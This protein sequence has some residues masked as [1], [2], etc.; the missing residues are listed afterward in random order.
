[1]DTSSPSTPS[2]FLSAR[3]AFLEDGEYRG[4][5]TGRPTASVSSGRRS[6]HHSRVPARNVL[7]SSQRTVGRAG[8]TDTLDSSQGTPAERAVRLRPASPVE[9]VA[10]QPLSSA[11]EPVACNVH[12]SAPMHLPKQ[13]SG[14][15]GRSV[16]GSR[17]GTQR[18]VQQ[19]VATSQCSIGSARSTEVPDPRSR[20][21]LKP[22][23]TPV[24]PVMRHVPVEP[25]AHQPRATPAEPIAWNVHASAPMHSPKQSSGSLGRSV[26]DSRSGTQRDV[27]QSDPSE[28]SRNTIATS[29]RSIRSALNP[30]SRSL[31]KP[32]VTPVE[33]AMGHVTVEHVAFQPR[34]STV[35]PIAWKVH[36]SAPMLSP[37]QSSGSFGRS[38]PGSR[39]C[40]QRDVQHS[41]ASELFDYMRTTSPRGISSARSTDVPDFRFRPL[42]DPRVTPV[43]PVVG[44]VLVEPVVQ[45][46]RVISTEHIVWNA[47]AIALVP[48]PALS[49]RSLREATEQTSDSRTR[50]V[51]TAREPYHLDAWSGHHIVVSSSQPSMGSAGST[52]VPDPRPT[53]WR[54]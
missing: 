2:R 31:Q 12:A 41:D 22:L 35:E 47:G 52:E 21:L 26:P 28:F 53:G 20:S 36:A 30:R 19:S 45:K 51:W 6:R 25:V 49:A 54:S 16:P 48:S 24:E 3:P 39:S 18:D 23:V 29:Q 9:P 15:F 5:A 17:S 14:S 50:R 44:L 27:Q 46:P 43:E 4:E 8:T 10:D 38:V 7:A 33:P 13:S 40:I 42:Q 1:M 37:K 32:L 34:S 11:V